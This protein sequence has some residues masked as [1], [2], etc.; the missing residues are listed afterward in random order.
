MSH[1]RLLRRATPY[2]VL[3]IIV[4]SAARA[5]PAAGN[6][7]AADLAPS[8]EDVYSGRAGNLGLEGIENV[9]LFDHEDRDI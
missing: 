5:E 6:A 3:G 7:A 9:T 2:L 8:E 1:S 4:S